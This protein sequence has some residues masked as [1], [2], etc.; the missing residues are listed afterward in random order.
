MVSF[1]SK[2][3][4]QYI[5]PLQFT[6]TSW[7]WS[8]GSWIYN[9]L[10]NQ[11]LSPLKV[12]IRI[13]LLVMCS[14]NN[15]S[16]QGVSVICGKSMVFSGF[17]DFPTNKSDRRDITEILMK[18]ALN[19]ITPC[20]ITDIISGHQSYS[21]MLISALIIRVNKYWGDIKGILY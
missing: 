18:M 1:F 20:N 11:C 5:F 6:E 9:Y 14:R 3:F 16:W 15:I 12:W 19:T 21:L 17:S 2:Y 8:Y 13:T 10:C 4:R 7:S